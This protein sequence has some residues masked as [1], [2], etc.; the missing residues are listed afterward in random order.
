V[1]FDFATSVLPGWHTT[2]FPPYFVAG[3]IFSG[4]AHGAHADAS[5]RASCSGLKDLITLAP[6]RQHVQGHPGDRAPWSATPTAWSSSSPGTGGNAYE[7]FAFINRAFGPY[8]VGLL[9]HGLLQRDHA[10]SSS[11]SRS[12]RRT[13][14]VVFVHR[15]SS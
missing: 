3:A 4:F 12:L 10:R 15:R 14:D 13:P 2:I 11:G 8:C 1:S 9:D 5:R 6:P 7:Q